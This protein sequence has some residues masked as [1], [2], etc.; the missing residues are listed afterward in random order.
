[1]GCFSTRTALPMNSTAS[2]VGSDTSGGSAASE[3]WERGRQGEEGGRTQLQMGV[4]C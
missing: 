3:T 2:A 1:M 4:G